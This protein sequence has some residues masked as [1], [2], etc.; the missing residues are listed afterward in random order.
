MD[1]DGGNHSPDGKSVRRE[2]E[3]ENTV[4]DVNSYLRCKQGSNGFLLFITPKII[5]ISFLMH[6]QAI[7]K[8][9]LDFALS[10][11]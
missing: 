11:S 2:A 1:S 10:L 4:I 3:S 9:F 6:A 8:P 7:M 5:C